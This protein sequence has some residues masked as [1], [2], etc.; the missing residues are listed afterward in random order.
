[1]PNIVRGG[2]RKELDETLWAA[3]CDRAAVSPHRTPGHPLAPGAQLANVAQLAQLPFVHC[4][5]W[6]LFETTVP[7]TYE[8]HA[9]CANTGLQKSDAP[10]G[11]VH[12][13]VA[14]QAAVQ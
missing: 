2:P 9:D 13:F 3:R 10:G 7:W 14:Q 1:M 5:L 4:Q 6:P 12:E 11:V 8:P